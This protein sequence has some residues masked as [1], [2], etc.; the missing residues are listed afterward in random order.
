M[1]NFKSQLRS[2]ITGA[3]ISATGG[4]VFVAQAGTAKK[5]TIYSPSTGL[6]ITNPM[7][8]TNGSFNFNVPDTVQSVDLYILSPTGHMTVLKGVEPSG[9]ASIMLDDKSLDTTLVIPFSATDQ[10]GDA[11][12]TDTLFVLPGAVQPNVAVQV[13]A[14]DATE[15]ILFGT[16][17]SDSGDADGFGVG[18]SGA[19][20]GYIKP[21]L[22]NGGTT[23]G[24]LLFV[25]DSANAGDEAPEQNVSMIGK[26]VTYTLSA[27]SDTAQGFLVLPVRLPTTIL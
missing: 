2:L 18:I 12:E 21:T 17:A 11:T 9:D 4:V 22:V 13:T 26:K 27:G 6:A 14:T 16:L 23:L 19:T 10:T 1:K 25:Q 24:A 5:Q 20:S 3:L 15:T 7:A 8:L